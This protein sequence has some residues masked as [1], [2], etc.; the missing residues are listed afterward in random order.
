VHLP[1]GVVVEGTAVGVDDDGGLV[2]H[3]DHGERIFAAGDVVHVRPA[4]GGLA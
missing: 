1:A 3:T 4:A 2:V